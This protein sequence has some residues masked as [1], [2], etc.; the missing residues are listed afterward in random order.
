[1]RTGGHSKVRHEGRGHQKSPAMCV[2]SL[3]GLTRL[4]AVE[5]NAAVACKLV[6]LG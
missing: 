3:G 1:M 6:T 2:L 4:A 5:L